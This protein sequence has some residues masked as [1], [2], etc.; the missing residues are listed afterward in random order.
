MRIKMRS[1]EGS[2]PELAKAE[3]TLVGKVAC[4]VGLL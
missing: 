2:K 1:E 3:T 4:V